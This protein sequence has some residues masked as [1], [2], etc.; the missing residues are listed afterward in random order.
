ML[1]SMGS[2]KAEHDLVNEEQ[3]YTEKDHST[4]SLPQLL[5]RAARHTHTR[6]SQFVLKNFYPNY[7]F[8]NT[9]T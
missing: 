2:Q 6:F 3:N 5:S 7:K 9:N 8:R 1:Q 4:P